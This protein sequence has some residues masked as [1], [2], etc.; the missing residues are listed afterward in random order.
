VDKPFFSLGQ[1]SRQLR[2]STP[3]Y[4]YRSNYNPREL[5]EIEGLKAKEPNLWPSRP[6]VIWGPSPNLVK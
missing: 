4:I 5:V 1:D 3:F 2:G 6:D